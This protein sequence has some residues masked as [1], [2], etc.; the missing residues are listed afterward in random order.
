MDNRL[1]V[2]GPI[3]VSAAAGLSLLHGISGSRAAA[4]M[5]AR[6]GHSSS[7]R[8]PG[9]WHC[10]GGKIMMIQVAARATTMTET[11]SPRFRLTEAAIMSH[12]S[13]V[14]VIGSLNLK[15]GGLGPGARASAQLESIAFRVVR[16]VEL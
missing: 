3:G 10:R 14:I 7:G 11:L 1:R 4:A 6:P 5:I 9:H 12:E 15:I 2:G 8:G 13:S 16:R